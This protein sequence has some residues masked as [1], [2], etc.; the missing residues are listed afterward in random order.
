MHFRQSFSKLAGTPVV[1]NLNSIDTS[2]SKQY[3]SPPPLPNQCWFPNSNR[4]T[5]QIQKDR[6]PT[7]NR[8]WGGRTFF[9]ING[10]WAMCPNTSEND[11]ICTW[12]KQAHGY[13]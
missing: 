11:C 6:V 4:I 10:F 7:L 1:L 12:W 8:G 9:Q 13:K 2:F 3:P 5:H